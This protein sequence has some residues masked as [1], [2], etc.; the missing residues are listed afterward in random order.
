MD[1][2]KRRES[3][4][5]TREEGKDTGLKNVGIASGSVLRNI[6]DSTQDALSGVVDTNKFAKIDFPDQSLPTSGTLHIFGS[7][8]HNVMLALPREAEIGECRDRAVLEDC[9]R[10]N[11]TLCS[12]RN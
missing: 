2:V 10:F 4:T 1:Y 12:E 8:D 6:I 5:Y 11:A 9:K 3:R 7:G